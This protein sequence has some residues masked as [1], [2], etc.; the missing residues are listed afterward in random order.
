MS[1][2][3]TIVQIVLAVILMALILIQNREAG[4]G[5][6]FGGTG[7]DSGNAFRTKRGMEKTIF[8][9]TIIFAILFLGISL[10][11]TFIRG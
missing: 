10:A 7:G 11:N 4:V 1:N 5:G 2:V 6:I 3:I 8:I 9:L